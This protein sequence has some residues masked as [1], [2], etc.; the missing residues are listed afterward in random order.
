MITGEKYKEFIDGLRELTKRTGVQVSGSS[1]RNEGSVF[2]YEANVG[3]Y[4]AGDDDEIDNE[5]D[6]VWWSNVVN[7]DKC[8]DCKHLETLSWTKNH[9]LP[10]HRF[11]YICPI[12]TVT[13]EDPE[14]PPPEGCKLRTPGK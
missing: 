9:G 8:S 11:S 2:L 1:F 3:D 7:L 10:P 13:I 4:M 5:P 12:S 6:H 14:N